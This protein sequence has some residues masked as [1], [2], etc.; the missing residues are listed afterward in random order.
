M[1]NGLVEVRLEESLS[2]VK[3]MTESNNECG[4]RE[5]LPTYS[6]VVGDVHAIDK[7]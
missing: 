1:R 7:V 5:L 3:L 6:S 4:G 2:L